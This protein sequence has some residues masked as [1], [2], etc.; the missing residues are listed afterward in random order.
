MIQGIWFARR[1]PTV[2]VPMAEQTE[3]TRRRFVAR[4]LTEFG[5]PALAFAGGVGIVTRNGL[6]TGHNKEARWQPKKQ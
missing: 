1:T 4:T 6:E 5:L 3:S 2:V